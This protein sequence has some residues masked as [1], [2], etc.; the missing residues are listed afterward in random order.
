MRIPELKPVVWVWAALR[1]VRELPAAVQN[2]LGYAL[3]LAQTGERHPHAKT[4]K[5]FGGSGV[6][7]IIEDHD[8][9][10]YRCV[11]TV[12]FAEAIYVLHAFQKKSTRGIATAKH[13][14]ALIRAR[15]DQAEALHAERTKQRRTS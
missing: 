2:A 8:G 15:L 12:H 1:E 5:G 10:T 3:Y 11:Y 4:L 7:E 13:I 6:L 9:S 14:I